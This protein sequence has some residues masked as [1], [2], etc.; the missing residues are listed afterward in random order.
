[1]ARRQAVLTLAMMRLEVAETFYIILYLTFT[2]VTVTSG[3][4]SISEERASRW[5]DSTD[6][7][8]G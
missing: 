4:E 3:R 2:Y 5:Y 7:G 8:Y 1:M 6:T